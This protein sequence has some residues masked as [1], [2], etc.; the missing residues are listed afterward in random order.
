MRKSNELR[1]FLSTFNRT[2]DED[3]LK[4]FRF[5]I[6]ISGFAR[7]GWQKMSGLKAVVNKVEYR[8]GGD[9]ATKRKSPGLVDFSDVVLSRGQIL[10]A[11]KGDRDILTWFTQVFDIAAKKPKAS[12]VFRRT[13]DIIQQD[14]ELNEVRRWRLKEAWPCEWEPTGD[15]D[16]EASADNIESITIC[17]EGYQ[18]VS[19]ARAAL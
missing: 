6:E 3:P 14:R 16:G 18:L 10:A 7:G 8:E 2:D 1:K 5:L 11:G 15:F 9:N 12:K 4:K 19:S 17:H 13:I